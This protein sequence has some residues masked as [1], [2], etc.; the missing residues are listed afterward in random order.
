MASLALA[1]GRWE[2]DV[3]GGL[4]PVKES[5]ACETNTGGR[6][7][8]ADSNPPQTIQSIRADEIV[9]LEGGALVETSVWPG[10]AD[11]HAGVG[12]VDAQRIA[13]RID[14]FTL[15]IDFQ[16]ST[17]Q[18]GHLLFILAGKGFGDF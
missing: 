14:V 17:D 2:R 11:E 3:R 18:D 6:P 9:K 16:L 8:A 7:G 4:D 1:R 15:A 10:R 13:P 5:A 12:E